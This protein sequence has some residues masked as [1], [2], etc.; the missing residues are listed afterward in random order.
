MNSTKNNPTQD[1]GILFDR[2]VD[3]ELSEAERRT[4]L[5]SL[6][7]QPEGWRR[8]A[9][10]FLAAQ[11]WRESFGDL[12]PRKAKASTSPPPAVQ[13]PSSIALKKTKKPLGAM[14]TAMAMAA[15]FL[16]TLGLGYWVLH[17]PHAGDSAAPGPTMIVD[18]G[19]PSRGSVP[20]STDERVPLPR[21]SLGTPWPS[22]SSAST[23][24][25]MVQLRAPGLTGDDQPLQL[26]ALPR[27]RLD[28]DFLKTVPDPLP[29]EVRK[30]LERTGHDIRTHRELVPVKLPDGRQLVIPVDQVDV[31]YDR[32]LAN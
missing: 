24:W 4:L 14:R 6:D 11:T 9:L 22:Q 30:A 8:C 12:I 21:P 23:P 17:V 28:E 20:V 26:P 3:G 15:S 13:Q 31:Q 16:V 29:D 25:Q 19:S 27:E 1:H 5:A 32:H 2:L 10:A 7:A 18:N